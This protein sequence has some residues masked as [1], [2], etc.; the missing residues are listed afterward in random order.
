MSHRGRAIMLFLGLLLSI[1]AMAHGPGW[2]P[3]WCCDNRD[4]AELPAGSVT[5]TKTGYLVQVV[6]N[7]APLRLHILQA[8]AKPSEDEKFHLCVMPTPGGEQPFAA[9]CFFAPPLGA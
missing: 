7:G 4:C 6:V 3:Q 1:P 8:D 5:V 9:R 2:Y